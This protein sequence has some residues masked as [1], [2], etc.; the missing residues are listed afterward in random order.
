M[1]SLLEL[2]R[3]HQEASRAGA[4]LVGAAAIYELPNG[5]LQVTTL[6]GDA[7]K[8]HEVLRR[9]AALSRQCGL[10]VLGVAERLA[11]E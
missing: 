10:Q 7:D 3:V 4:K 11:K 5:A 6:F 8:D 9:A 1:V 2:R